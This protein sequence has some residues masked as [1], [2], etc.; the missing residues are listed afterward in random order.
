[1]LSSSSAADSDGKGTVQSTISPDSSPEKLPVKGARKFV[2]LISEKEETEKRTTGDR[3]DS[4]SPRKVPV[5]LG[6]GRDSVGVAF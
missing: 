3:K 1:M 6:H 5:P 2:G 4:W